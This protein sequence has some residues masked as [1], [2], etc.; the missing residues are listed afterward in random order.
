MT[1][2]RW[3]SHVGPHG[4]INPK[5]SRRFPSPFIMQSDVET[6][7]PSYG[8]VEPAVT[9]LASNLLGFFYRVGISPAKSQFESKTGLCVKVGGSRI[10]NVKHTVQQNAQHRTESLHMLY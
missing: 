6:G 2:T 9:T 4:D 3:S 7:S 1:L 8:S 10:K 5:M